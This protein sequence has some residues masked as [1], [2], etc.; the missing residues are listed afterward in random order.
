MRKLILIIFLAACIVCSSEVINESETELIEELLKKDDL[1]L[2][3]LNFLKDWSGSTKFKIPLIVDILNNPLEFPVFVE[4][5]EQVLMEQDILRLTDFFYYDCLSEI[6]GVNSI[7]EPEYPLP[8]INK[9][10]PKKLF[11]FVENIWQQVYTEYNKAFI[12]LEQEEI[13]K[14]EYFLISVYQEPQDSLEYQEYF[15]KNDQKEFQDL[16][17]EEIIPIL[18]KVDF[19]ALIKGGALFIRGFSIVADLCSQLEF[20][21][22]KTYGRD[23]IWGKFKIGTAGNDFYQDKYAFIFDPGGDDIYRNTFSTD[24]KYPFYWLVDNSGDDHYESD[25]IGGMFSVFSGYGAA[26]DRAGSDVYRSGDFLISVSLGCQWLVDEQGDDIYTGG[27]HSLGA[28]T[29][30]I[31]CLQDIR[32]DDFYSVTEFGQGFG[33]V[34]GIGVIADHAGND[35]YHAGGRYLHAPLAPFD[36]RSLSQGFGYGLRPDLGGG[37]GILYDEF[38][39]DHYIGGVYAQGVAYWYALGILIDRQGNDFYD[40][41]YYPQG[42]GIHLA[43]GFLLDRAGEDHYYS[44]HGPGQ[45]A[46]HDYAVG[47]LVDRGGNDSYSVEGGNGLG[48]TNS[49]GIFLDVSGNDN[50]GRKYDSN[51]G[52]ANQARNSGG[53]GLFL[54][55]GGEDVYTLER[56]RDN[57]NWRAGTYGLGIDTMMVFIT[58]AVTEAAVEE[59]VSVDSLAEIAEIFLIA[60]EW[61][62]GS[63]SKR[64]EKAGNI[65]LQ[66][67]AEAALYISRNKMNTK[68]GLTYRAINLFAENSKYFREFFPE[69]LQHEDTLVIKNTIN[70]IGDLKDT[71]YIE[72]LTDF[73][74][75]GKY[76]NTVLASLG[77]MK[78]DKVSDILAEY[79]TSGIEKT[80]IIAARGLHNINSAY[81]RELLMQMSDDP[82]FLIRTMIRLQE[83]KE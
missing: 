21:A 83:E 38:G 31:S 12:N 69:L 6:F 52:Y 68:S 60:S 74:S 66:R 78:T 15:Q 71:T 3:S 56:C 28:A 4:K 30:G 75:D 34:L 19:S 46:G 16:S 32:G 26:L 63:A 20:P 13:E 49:V 61:G 27:L 39:N 41:V 64:V 79:R 33:G 70:I 23:T 67:E 37:I 81:S 73:L 44:K 29:C 51:Y 72:V 53:I 42:S 11:D 18:E 40:A 43:G 10:R 45:G 77:N 5:C 58:E 17:V 2:N 59:A 80:R 55:S 1:D 7:P 54:D 62:V 48:L 14:L 50:Y 47:F 8:E 24:R 22:R 25:Q 35:L 82:S 65:L 76:V 9:L 36:Y 57:S